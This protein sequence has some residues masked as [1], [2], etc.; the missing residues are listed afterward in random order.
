MRVG[1]DA[2]NIGGGGG[3]THLKEILAYLEKDNQAN[4]DISIV[5]FSSDVVLN[6]LNDTI[7]IKKVTFPNLNKTLFHRLLFQLLQFDK[8]IS[9]RCDI[10]FSLTGDYTGSF[11]PLVGMSQN[12][13]LYERKIWKEIKDFKEIFRF[14]I[15]FHKQKRC[16]KNSS[17]IIFI[18]NYA[19]NFIVNSLKLRN[20]ELIIINHGISPRFVGVPKKQLSIN[21]YNDKKPFKLLYVS[22]VHVYKHQ[23]N[24]INAVANLRNKGIPIEL[25]LVGGVIYKPSGEKMFETLNNVDAKKTFIKYHGDI[26]YN[27]ID[28]FYLNTDAIVFASSCENMPNILIESMASSVPIACSNKQ[29]MP[30]FL[31][32]G[33]YYFDSNSVQSIENSISKLIQNPFDRSNMI[34]DN[35]KEIQNYSWGKT[36]KETFD[37]IKYIYNTTTHVKK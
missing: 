2:T 29:P 21:E 8:E 25:N 9:N 12:M 14:W 22:T 18:S 37:F 10:L 23:W 3:I 30:E 6:Q 33:G 34:K 20:K 32:K 15:I 7:F 4:N 16:F 31:K 26:S 11:K 27:E 35:L 24:V 36:S 13:L 28:S 17:G 1:I 5:V 19:K